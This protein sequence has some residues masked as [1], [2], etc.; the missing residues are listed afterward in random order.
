[1]EATRN[2]ENHLE[3]PEVQPSGESKMGDNSTRRSQPIAINKK[4]LDQHVG[5][6]HRE[7]PGSTNMFPNFDHQDLVETIWIL[8][9]DLEQVVVKM[10]NILRK[11]IATDQFAKLLKESDEMGELSQQIFRAEMDRRERWTEQQVDQ[12]IESKLGSN[13]WGME[14][15]DGSRRPGARNGQVGAAPPTHP[16][17]RPGQEQYATGAYPVQPSEQTSGPNHYSICLNSQSE[18]SRSHLPSHGGDAAGAMAGGTNYQ[19]RHRRSRDHVRMEPFSQPQNEKV[20]A[21]GS[22]LEGKQ[23]I[24]RDYVSL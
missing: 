21:E 3:Q 7:S 5:Q 23:D 2:L 14:A 12:V 19:I 8:F 4:K 16:F 1:M 6:E 22:S 15:V 11:Y 10:L 13:H 9:D 18:E 24:V 17:E 20:K